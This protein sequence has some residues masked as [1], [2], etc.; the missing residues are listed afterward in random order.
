M[1]RRKLEIVIAGDSSGA[2]KAFNAVKGGAGAAGKAFAAMGA[3]AIAGVGLAGA[4]VIKFGGD[5]D[6]ARNTIAIGTGA[7]GENLDAL[8]DDFKTTLASV[9]D[10]MG[11]VSEAIATA[12]TLF[13]VTGDELSTLTERTLD[14]TRLAGG[15]AAAN[16]E[17][18]GQAASIFGLDA[19][20][21][22]AGL[23]NLFRTTQDFNIAGDTLLGQLQT[24]GPI[25][26]N[27]GFS[28][29]Q[30]AAIMGQLHA[31]GV[32]LSRVGPALN[33]FFRRTAEAGREPISA[34]AET[35]A[36]IR[37]A[38]TA[39]EA[40]AIAT[41]A[42]GAEGAQRMTNAIREGGVALTDFAGILDD[43]A[44]LIDSTTA[45]T[46]TMGEKWDQLVNQ[47][48]VEA[49]PIISRLFDALM[50]GMDWISSTAVPAVR[51][52]IAVFNDQG[53]AGVFALVRDRLAAAWPA[54]QEALGSMA[55]AFV[56]WLGQVIPPTLEKLGEWLAALGSWLID[57][58]LPTAAE[59]LVELGAAFIEWIVPLIPPALEELGSL[60]GA[61]FDWIIDT[62]LPWAVETLAEL[63]VEFVKW[64]APLIP[65]LLE[66]LLKLGAAMVDWIITDAIPKVLG[67][68]GELAL[69]FA[70]WVVTD[71][72]PDV[73]AEIPGLATAIGDWIV[74]DAVPTLLTKAGELG[75]AIL[76]GILDGLSGFAQGAA[77]LAGDVIG[78][79]NDIARGAINGI[80]DAI[81]DMLPD[82]IGKISVAGVTIFPGLDLPNNP[83]PRI[84]A[85][86]VFLPPGASSE[87]L[88]ILKRGERVVTPGAASL[89]RGGAGP[90]AGD[91][92]LEVNVVLDTQVLV[93]ALE[94]YG[95]RRGPLNIRV[96]S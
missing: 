88:A 75:K 24:F 18:L 52:M 47:V 6:E 4:A 89:R 58:G 67:A 46:E 56:D 44:G 21:A 80:I 83:I 37:N 38:G 55:S 36:A 65:P 33:A 41:D 51:T 54:I 20:E 57:T 76:D 35:E 85:G 13:G 90:M 94:N 45:E 91:R 30:T 82:S 66:E 8:F 63:A 16:T 64:V 43:N 72:I 50:R 12:N 62:G 7:T 79:V 59:K 60:F 92:P 27:A 49:E 17:A 10:D 3:A 5:F 1:A 29:E 25:F 34:L 19:G 28:M 26:A 73:M 81:N 68:L 70:G 86:G 87:G 39:S 93:S 78:A 9:P 77:G 31:S 22:T 69:K 48:L 42:F 96:A 11:V 23:D 14:F 84:H 53:L 15:D 74:T 61:A 40:L 71:L 32:D 95:R 2:E